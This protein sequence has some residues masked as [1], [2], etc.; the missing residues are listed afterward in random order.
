MR[1]QQRALTDIEYKIETAGEA[2]A[3]VCDPQQQFVPEQ[4]VSKVCRLVGKIELRGQQAAARCLDLDV[5]MSCATR[6]DCRHDRAKTER[7]I[8]TCDDMAAIAEAGI[9][10]LA[11]LVGVPE[12]DDRAAERTATSRQH[13]AG[14]FKLAATGAGFA[15]VGALRRFWLEERALGLARGRRIAIATRGRG[16]KPLRQGMFGA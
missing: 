15:Q 8:G 11:F 16:R 2:V 1:R 5:I 3:G 12:I 4:A 7:A 13:K 10:V 9:V 6:V 14:Q